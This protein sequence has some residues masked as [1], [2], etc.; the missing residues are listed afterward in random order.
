M[1]KIKLVSLLLV[2]FMLA[3]TLSACH[4]EPSTEEWH[5]FSYIKKMQF[6][7]GVELE[8]GFS[9]ASAAYPFA[10]ADFS[11]VHISFSAGNVNF[12]TWDGDALEGVYTCE[13]VGNYTKVY[14]TFN[15]GD[16]VEGDAMKG[17]WGES[18]FVFKYRD[19]QYTFSDQKIEVKETLDDIVK[20]V[21]EGT[22]KSLHPATVSAAEDGYYVKFNDLVTY[23]IAEDTA[24]YAIKIAADGSH[25][26]LDEILEGEV[27]STYNED[28]N[29]IVL[30][31][32]EK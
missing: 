22:A 25:T 7:G 10:N 16:S 1:R 14:M 3:V 32:I 4:C 13:N 5:L 21:K 24:A 12:V 19:V 2:I 17:F 11:K 31:Y 9:T 18:R 15:N 29:Y 23:H 20:S 27:L 28:A 8:L 26:I 30:Y 6:I